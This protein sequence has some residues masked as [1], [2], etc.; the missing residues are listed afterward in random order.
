MILTG[1]AVDAP[2]AVELGLV[3]AVVP[4][5][6]LL[7]AAHTLAHRITRHAPSAVTACLRAVTRGINLPIDEGLAVEAAWFAGAVGT[8]AVRD[9]LARFLDSR[10]SAR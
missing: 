3:N 4:A 5:A 1:D 6:E 10:G 7:D 9:G 8:E 2:R